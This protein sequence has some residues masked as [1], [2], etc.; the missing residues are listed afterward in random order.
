MEKRISPPA[1]FEDLLIVLTDPAG[2]GAPPAFETKQKALMFAAALGFHRGS[3]Q[4]LSKRG[5]AIRADVFAADA[6]DGFLLALA[7]AATGEVSILDPERAEDRQTIFEE[8]AAG[9]LRELAAMSPSDGGFVERCLRLTSDALAAP[10]SDIP[11]IDRSVLG[12]LI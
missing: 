10:E 11:G 1:E 6:D 3:R 4:Q 8:Y 2:E 9:G 12:D 5:T 7:L